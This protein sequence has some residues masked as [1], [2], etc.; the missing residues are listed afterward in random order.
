MPDK[1]TT[2]IKMMSRNVKLASS[3]LET[4]SNTRED[5]EE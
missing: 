5:K 4:I 1:W 3:I 2:P